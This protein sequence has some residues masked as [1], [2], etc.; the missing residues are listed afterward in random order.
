MEIQ[1]VEEI[2]KLEKENI[3]IN[4]ILCLDDIAY[5]DIDVHFTMKNHRYSQSGMLYY[6]ETVFTSKLNIFKF[7]YEVDCGCVT[8][9][10]DMREQWMKIAK[11]MKNNL[12]VK[13]LEQVPYKV[14]EEGD[15][16]ERFCK[17]MYENT[18]LRILSIDLGYSYMDVN[19][20]TVLKRLIKNTHITKVLLVRD[21][22][23]HQTKLL[24]SKARMMDAELDM[25][26]QIPFEERG[27]EV[28]S[29]TK[30]AAKTS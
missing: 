18:T 6:I 14:F 7:S 9:D 11:M 3:D 23:H 26:C 5:R 2:N 21:N 20:E 22:V 25:Y 27:V 17:E 16:F 19:N 28:K 1:N 4:R 12:N 10:V 24:S 30:S 29:K 8:S 15:S 13:I